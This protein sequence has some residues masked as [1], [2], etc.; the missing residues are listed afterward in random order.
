MRSYLVDE[1]LLQKHNKYVEKHDYSIYFSEG[2]SL[3][4]TKDLIED[5]YGERVD[6]DDR[7]YHKK[8]T[9]PKTENLNNK[10][11]VIK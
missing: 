9:L 7:V 6:E 11:E 10:K 1:I 3:E 8:I 4:Y 2:F 5:F